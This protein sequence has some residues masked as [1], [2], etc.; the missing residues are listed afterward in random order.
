MREI[1]DS[2][3]ILDSQIRKGTKILKKP[4]M[5]NAQGYASKFKEQITPKEG[6]KEP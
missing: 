3:N 2:R 6:R 4:K 5:E 1:P